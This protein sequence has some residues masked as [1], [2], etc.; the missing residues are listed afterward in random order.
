MCYRISELE[1]S[2]L[3]ILLH[4]KNIAKKAQLEGRGEQEQKGLKDELLSKNRPKS[5]MDDLLVNYLF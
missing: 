2:M 5:E 3:M 1:Q 4:F